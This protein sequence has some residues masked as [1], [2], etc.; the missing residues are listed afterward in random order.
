MLLPLASMVHNKVQQGI[1]SDRVPA[2]SDHWIA[3]CYPGH[4]MDDSSHLL[5]QEM[6]LLIL[7]HSLRLS[8]GDTGPEVPLTQKFLFHYPL[9]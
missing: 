6:V 2:L 3:D 5:R 4:D 8:P 1:G 7:S 9:Q